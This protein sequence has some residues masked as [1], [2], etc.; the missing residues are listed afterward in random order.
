M[1][2]DPFMPI[3]LALFIASVVFCFLAARKLLGVI[4]AM[5]FM[6]ALLVWDGSAI[7]FNFASELF[8]IPWNNQVLFF[9]FAF[10]F[11]LFITQIKKKPSWKILIA[12]AFI[13]GY[14]FLTRQEAILFIIPTV[15]AFL[16]VT[17]TSWKKSLVVFSLILFC[18]TL[19]LFVN[20]LVNHTVF[21]SGREE[22]YS[23][24]SRGYLQPSLL[25]RNIKEVIIGSSFYQNPDTAKP[26]IA[27]DRQSLLQAAPWLWLAPIGVMLIFI[28]KRYP[29]G[30]KIFTII[31]ILLM[32]FYLSGV[33]MSGQ[34]LRYHT[35][36]YISSGFIVLNLGL[37]IT[38]KE[39]IGLG[40]VATKK[41]IKSIKPQEPD[42]GTL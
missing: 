3:A 4:W 23:K 30:L 13:S 28:L 27:A 17:K 20:F 11:W 12:L 40:G 39:G 41:L 9:T 10:Y 42:K 37:A 24:I 14:C 25:K 38:I 31:S 21:S 22:S 29:L 5:V 26:P 35:L 34:K 33:N 8:A 2:S 19:Q 18:F 7:T 36:R 6:A 1:P 32:L 16:L 15:L